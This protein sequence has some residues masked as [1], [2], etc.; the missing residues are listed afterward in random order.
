[1]WSLRT[2]F[3]ELVLVIWYFGLVKR[4]PQFHLSYQ[5]ENYKVDSVSWLFFHIGWICRYKSSFIFHI[6]NLGLFCIFPYLFI[7]VDFKQH[8]FLNFINGIRSFFCFLPSF[9]CVH[10]GF[11]ISFPPSCFLLLLSLLFP[12]LADFNSFSQFHGSWGHGGFLRCHVSLSVTLC[13]NIHVDVYI[14]SLF[15]SKYL[16][17]YFLVSS[18]SPHYLEVCYFVWNIWELF[19]DPFQI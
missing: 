15:S 7:G 12:F 8:F 10:K 4:F 6:H 9:L 16:P 2:I 13:H 18:L 11:I 14:I 3:L 17:C 5:T 19:S 1:M